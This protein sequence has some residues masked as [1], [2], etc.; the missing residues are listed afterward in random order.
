MKNTVI[1]ILK[2][3]QNSKGYKLK[4]INK[5]IKIIFL[6]FYIL[7]FTSLNALDSPTSC[8]N[9]MF[10]KE[11]NQSINICNSAASNLFLA[12]RKNKDKME[13]LKEELSLSNSTSQKENL[14]KIFNYF[15][16]NIKYK[17][18]K[19]SKHKGQKVPLKTVVDWEG[20]CEDT[21]SLALLLLKSI[22]IEPY[23]LDIDMKDGS[24]GHIVLAIDV[25]DI[26]DFK[27][28]KYKTN[29]FKNT[30][31]SNILE[32]LIMDFPSDISKNESLEFGKYV[33]IDYKEYNN[34]ISDFYIF[35]TYENLFNDFF[36]DDCR[37]TEE[38]NSQNK[39]ILLN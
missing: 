31:N 22:S 8:A 15:I 27:K 33:S 25:N 36:N 18:D 39:F 38:Q 16:Y 12:Y 11:L 19:Y 6:Y 7:N 30:K 35:Q 21:S 34:K 10:F 17:K 20:D 37:Y 1:L 13:C 2:R 9:G 4:L 24:I 14:Q 5:R 26:E 28:K 29:K 3:N 23:I 32:V